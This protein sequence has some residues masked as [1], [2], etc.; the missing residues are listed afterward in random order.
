MRHRLFSA[1][2]AADAY[3]AKT[4]LDGH[5]YS[6]VNLNGRPTLLPKPFTYILEGDNRRA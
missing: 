5:L 2:H 1:R 6:R 3:L 4:S